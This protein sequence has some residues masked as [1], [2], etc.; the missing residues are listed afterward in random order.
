LPAPVR[1][2]GYA[3]ALCLTLLFTP[4]TGKT[5]IYFQF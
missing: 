4:M 2:F 3:A 1:G 5:F